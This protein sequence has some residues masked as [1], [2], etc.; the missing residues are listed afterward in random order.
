MYRMSFNH[1]KRNGDIKTR[2]AAAKPIAGLL[3]A[4]FDT[5]LK[6]FTDAVEIAEAAGEFREQVNRSFDVPDRDRFGADARLSLIVVVMQRNRDA[7][8]NVSGQLIGGRLARAAVHDAS[9]EAEPAV[10]L[11]EIAR[12]GIHEID[13]AMIEHTRPVA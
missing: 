12:A 3:P 13:H 7:T 10:A 2:L 6:L 9:L 8:C 1:N 11:R 4:A 5:L